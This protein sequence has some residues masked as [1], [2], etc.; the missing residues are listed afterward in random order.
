[1]LDRIRKAF[2][3][4]VYT[5]LINDDRLPNKKKGSVWRHGRLY[6]RPRKE[7]RL[8]LTNRSP[9]A[10][11]SWALL[12]AAHHLCFHIRLESPGG[13]D[14]IS[15]S[16]GIPYL[17]YLGG[18]VEGLV[19][20]EVKQW[21]GLY[22]PGAKTGD[23]YIDRSIGWSI[24]DGTAWISIWENDNGW[25]SR[26][27]KWWKFNFSINPLDL[28]GRKKY[29]SEVVEEKTVAIP[30]PEGSYPAKIKLCADTW[31]RP[32]WPRW[33]FSETILR[34]H[35]DMVKPIPTPGKGENSW[36]CGDDAVCGLTA[37]ARTM[38]EAVGK[39]VATALQDRQ[40]YGGSHEFTPRDPPPDEATENAPVEMKNADA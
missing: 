22:N 26:D 13:E 19:P 33:P 16:G 11:V 30:M 3:E 2:R 27:P 31:A 1:M 7:K 17:F 6:I 37:P 25:S 38:E 28:L 29:T 8:K 35:A 12:G 32:R 20:Q 10:H 4:N 21:I 24:H 34:M 9:E 36:D 23:V 14:D 18:S 40:R 39:L 5:H 15:I